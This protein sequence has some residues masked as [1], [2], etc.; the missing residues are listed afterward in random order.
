MAP[1][2]KFKPFE[3]GEVASEQLQEKVI[4]AIKTGKS[5]GLIGFK[6]CD[7][8]GTFMTDNHGKYWHCFVNSE[9]FSF[10]SGEL[11]AADNSAYFTIG[12]DEWI[13]FRTLG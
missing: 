2:I 6:L 5:K 3:D 9:H 1:K 11:Q 4:G 12:N 8:V 7:F 13:V 10:Y